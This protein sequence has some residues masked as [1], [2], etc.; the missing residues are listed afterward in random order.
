MMDLREPGVGASLDGFPTDV[1]APGRTLYRIC[2]RHNGTWWF[3]SDGSG[4]FDLVDVPGWGT[5]YFAADV[6]AS[7][8]EVFRSPRIDRRD[9]AGRTLRTVALALPRTLADT[10]DRTAHRFGITKEIA[11]AEPKDICQRWA[12]AWYEFGLEGVLHELRHDPE[13]T[14]SGVS[15]FGQQAGPDPPLPDGDISEI[16][17]EVLHRLGIQVDDAPPSGRAWLD[18]ND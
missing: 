7:L 9:V 11:T 10:T 13:P 14:A 2:R 15:L 3:S 17:D 1:W 12:F 18:D 8:L 5:C 4:R 16:P 6:E